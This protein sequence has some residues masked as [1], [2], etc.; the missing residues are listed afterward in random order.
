MPARDSKKSVTMAVKPSKKNNKKSKQ[1]KFLK[2]FKTLF[3]K[4]FNFS[5][6]LSPYVSTY[7]QAL[8]Q[9]PISMGYCLVVGYNPVDNKF[10]VGLLGGSSHEDTLSNERDFF[11]IGNSGTKYF[12]LKEI[13]KIIKDETYFYEN[14][15]P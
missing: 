1:K 13:K 3:K 10:F 15:V 14:S 11:R 9:K 4:G 8:L 12:T 7:R 6:E 2:T 5:S